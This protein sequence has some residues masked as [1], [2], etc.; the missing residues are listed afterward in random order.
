[1]ESGEVRKNFEAGFKAEKSVL[2]VVLTNQ[3]TL[4][5]HPGVVRVPPRTRLMSGS[6]VRVDYDEPITG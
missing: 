1:M 2:K 6:T 5:C 3:T 4:T